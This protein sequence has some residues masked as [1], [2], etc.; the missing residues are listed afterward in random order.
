L[1][2][3]VGSLPE[4]ELDSIYTAFVTLSYA[5]HWWN[6]HCQCLSI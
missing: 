3:A 4:N 2:A 5:I 6:Y 1:E